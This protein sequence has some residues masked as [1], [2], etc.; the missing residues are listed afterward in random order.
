MVTAKDAREQCQKHLKQSVRVTFLE[1]P[2][3]SKMDLKM[4]M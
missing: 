1:A 4:P 3:A 2:E